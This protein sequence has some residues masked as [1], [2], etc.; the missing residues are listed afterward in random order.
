[1]LGD[2]YGFATGSATKP[3]IVSKYNIFL[4]FNIPLE[5]VAAVSHANDADSLGYL[6]SRLMS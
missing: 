4:D 6:H 5:I 3:F 2:T 1:M